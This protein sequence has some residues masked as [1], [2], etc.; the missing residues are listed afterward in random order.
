[1]VRHKPLPDA[2][3]LRSVFN[4]LADGSL[5]WRERPVSHFPRDAIAVMWNKRF[6]GEVAG[7]SKKDGRRYRKVC[8]DGVHYHEHRIVFA[9]FNGVDPGA[10]QV[11][12]RDAEKKHPQSL[13]LTTNTLNI[14]R[15]LHVNKNNTSGTAGVVRNAK[16]WDVCIV[17]NRE[18]VY[19]GRFAKYEDAVEAR[20]AGEA[21][22]FSE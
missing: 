5:R 13:H 20:R 12:H 22:F 16:K 10:F 18:R 15:R 1:M 4:L 19:L 9:L 2:V 6:A 8:V 21:F 7:S 3:Y 11:D 17:F 14:R